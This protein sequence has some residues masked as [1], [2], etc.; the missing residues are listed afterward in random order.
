MT[1][2]GHG[3]SVTSVSYSVDGLFLVSGSDD[4]AVRVWDT[5]SGEEAISPLRSGSGPVTSVAFVPN[6]K[7]V[8]AGTG[9]GTVCSW[10]LLVGQSTMKQLVGH[11]GAVL[12]VAISSDSQ[13]LASASLDRTL[14]VWNFATGQ[15]ITVL[16]GH[17]DPT[18]GIAVSPNREVT[19]SGSYYF[20]AK[21][22]PRRGLKGPIHCRVSNTGPFMVSVEDQ[23]VCLWTHQNQDEPSLMRL[24]GH[25]A[26]VH[27][28]VISPNSSYVASASDDGTIRIWDIGVGTS[29]FGLHQPDRRSEG[30]QNCRPCRLKGPTS[31][32]LLMTV[33]LVFGV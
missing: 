22:P 26:A 1:L 15:L 25:T 16:N 33:Q 32:T 28:A 20:G 6:G 27:S 12:S 7:G 5:R 31:Y 2:K 19:T 4:G 14:R 18:K 29:W 24:E 13:F 17:E 21:E 11:S 9:T 10:S 3:G 23:N 8:V 30:N